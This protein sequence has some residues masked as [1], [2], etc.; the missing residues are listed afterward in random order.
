MMINEYQQLNV[1]SEISV[2]KLGK[3]LSAAIKM[4]FPFIIYT[5]KSFGGE[6]CTH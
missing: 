4:Y 1:S 3:P 6:S 5:W 2:L